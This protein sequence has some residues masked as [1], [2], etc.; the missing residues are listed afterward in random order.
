MKVEAP[1]EDILRFLERKVI[2]RDNPN[3]TPVL[4]EVV[5]DAYDRLIAP[6]I[7]REIRSSLTEMAVAGIR[8]AAPDVNSQWS[9]RPEKC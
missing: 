3:T 7:E 1:E 5:A 2:T 8:H 9:I 6:A 4:K